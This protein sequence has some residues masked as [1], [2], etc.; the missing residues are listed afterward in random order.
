MNVLNAK[1]PALDPVLILSG[2]AL[3]SLAQLSCSPETVSS[4]D[5]AFAVQAVSVE[6]KPLRDSLSS[7][8]SITY[9]IKNDITVQVEG[10]ISSLYVK[11][12]DRVRAGQP[13]A[14]L[15]N[16]D[17]E[18]R[19]EQYENA[20]DAARAK[21]STA[22][23]GMREA[24]LAVEARILSVAKE[25]FSLTQQELEFAEA[26]E[27]LEKQRKLLSLGG[28]TGAAFRDMEVSLSAREAGIAVLKKDIEITR[29][30]LREEDLAAAGLEPSPDPAEKIR[31]FVEL[32][33][34]AAAAELEA[35]EAEQRNAEKNLESVNRLIGELLIRSTV[36]GVVGALYFE[37]G[38][39]VP[40][41]EKFA[42][43][44]DTSGVFAVFYIQEQDMIRFSEGAAVEIEIPSL[45]QRVQAKLDE[46]SPVADPQSGNF[47]VKA[48]LPN[49]DLSIKPGMFIRC[50]IP[51]TEELLLLSIPETALLADKDGRDYVFCAVKGAALI[52]AV[53]VHSRR[54]GRLWIEA[55]L[56]E[57]DM[58]IDKPSP[59]LKEGAPVEYR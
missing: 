45:G 48:S 59:F 28:L 9:R 27:A 42:T 11:E 30:G 15:R 23:T 33:T 56:A 36:S 2:L 22:R 18:T 35:A 57:G 41:N 25:E 43:L 46:I 21:L 3:F 40:Q 8:G 50:L 26:A 20:L 47:S 16:L 54:D 13:L 32:N 51:R 14:L 38:E 6:L 39:H 34:R 5:R 10:T 17:L 19:R 37:N 55:G 24:R 31:Q 7:F 12:G 49:P 52:K 4:D 53:E 58:V 1:I 29:L 44:M